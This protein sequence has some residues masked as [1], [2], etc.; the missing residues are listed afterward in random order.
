MASVV[1][2]DLVF[3]SLKSKDEGDDRPLVQRDQWSVDANL[4]YLRF[5]PYV[6]VSFQR[7]VKFVFWKL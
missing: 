7:D 1:G 5:K 3:W 4:N 2:T 6:C